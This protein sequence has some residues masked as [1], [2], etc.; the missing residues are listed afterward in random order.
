M[1]DPEPEEEVIR[2]AAGLAAY[3]S[4]GRDSS[5]V[6]VNYCPISQLKKIP[7]AKPGM[8]QLGNYHTI[9]IDPDPD[10]LRQNGIPI[11]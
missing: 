8:V 10:T 9:Y 6:P 2:F 1:H 7:G 4:K 11:D 3:Y 5:S